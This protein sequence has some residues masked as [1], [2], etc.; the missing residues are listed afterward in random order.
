MFFGSGRVGLF[1]ITNINEGRV[2]SRSG[3][4]IGRRI[5]E[6]TFEEY[7]RKI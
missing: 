1:L 6:R 2:K 5:F 3:R 7:L 4:S